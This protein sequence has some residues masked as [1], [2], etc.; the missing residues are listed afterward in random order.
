M[1]LASTVVTLIVVV[2][3]P[4]PGAAGAAHLA[5]ASTTPSGVARDFMAARLSR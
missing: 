4:V 5:R 1:A 2:F 3:T